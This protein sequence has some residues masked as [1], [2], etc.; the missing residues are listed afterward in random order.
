[1]YLVTSPGKHQIFYFYI[2]K[3]KL[4]TSMRIFPR[5]YALLRYLWIHTYLCIHTMSMRLLQINLWKTFRFLVFFLFFITYMR[6]QFEHLFFAKHFE[7]RHYKMECIG[8]RKTNLI[9]FI[10]MVKVL[11][12]WLKLTSVDT[13]NIIDYV[14][15]S[16]HS[17]ITYFPAES[18]FDPK[19]N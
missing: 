17:I 12:V 3:H 16:L 2:P 13:E 18:N 6:I 8:D 11:K 19:Y 14:T 5:Q 1:M 15:T 4:E 7:H 10:N 9:L